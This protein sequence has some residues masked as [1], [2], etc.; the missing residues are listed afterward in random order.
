MRCGHLP[1]SA[2]PRFRLR[3]LRQRVASRV[4]TKTASRGRNPPR[5]GRNHEQERDDQA[6]QGAA[7]AHRTHHA[8]DHRKSRPPL[9]PP[10]KPLT[11][12]RLITRSPVFPDD[13]SADGLTGDTAS[14]RLT[15]LQRILTDSRA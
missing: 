2:T 11:W 14:G 12:S 9:L 15:L 4:R 8:G 5:P 10:A 1:R 6:H 13:D 7:I 3:S